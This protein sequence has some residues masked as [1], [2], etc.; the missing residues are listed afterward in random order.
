MGNFHHGIEKVAIYHPSPSPGETGSVLY[1]TLDAEQSSCQVGGNVDPDRMDAWGNSPFPG[2]R[3]ELIVEGWDPGETRQTLLRTW[4]SAGTEVAASILGPGATF[5]IHWEERVLL[6]EPRSTN[7]H[8]SFAGR[9]DYSKFEMRAEGGEPKIYRPR[10]NFV[11]HL[12]PVD[13]DEKTDAQTF[14]FFFP[15]PTQNLYVGIDAVEESGESFDDD[16]QS[17]SLAFLDDQGASIGAAVTESTAEGRIEFNATA[18]AGVHRVR[19]TVPAAHASFMYQNL[20]VRGDGS[21]V[22]ING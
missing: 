8:T 20:S 21:Y 10:I 22:Y 7:I 16:G 2:G 12:D 1:S 15:F 13:E 11:A 18:P 6:N 5:I 9:S 4:Y 14:A 19:V 3:S 17:I